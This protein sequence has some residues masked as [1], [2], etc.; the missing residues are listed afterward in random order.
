M[1]SRGNIVWCD[2]NPV[3]GSEQAGIRPAVVGRELPEVMFH[4]AGL[5]DGFERGDTCT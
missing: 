1:I 4:A 3:I 5:V 2:F